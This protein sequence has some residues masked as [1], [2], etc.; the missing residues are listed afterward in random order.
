MMRADALLPCP[1]FDVGVR[2]FSPMPHGV[3]LRRAACPRREPRG[4]EFSSMTFLYSKVRYHI[5]SCSVWL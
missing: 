5:A 4:Y 2:G 1:A 3:D